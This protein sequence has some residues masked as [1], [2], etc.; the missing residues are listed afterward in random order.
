MDDSGEVPVDPYVSSA[1]AR[2]LRRPCNREGV[3]LEERGRRPGPLSGV[4]DYG[5]GVRLSHLS[6]AGGE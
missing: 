4:C 2:L 6:R 1:G 5:D 3:G